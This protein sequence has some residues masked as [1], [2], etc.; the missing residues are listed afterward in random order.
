M[1]LSV[2]V[3]AIMTG[4]ALLVATST[5]IIEELNDRSKRDALSGL[6]NRRGFD[7]EAVDL[8]TLAD[9]FR[10]PV[11]VIIADID[12]FK[13]VNDTH[14]HA[15]GDIV[16]AELGAV[17]ASYAD[18]DRIAGRIG[19]EEFAL[20][21]P[22][23]SGE[24]AR[25]IAEAIRAEFA[26]IKIDTTGGAFSFTASFGAGERRCGEDAR[27]ALAKADEALYLAK[28]AGRNCVCG[29]ADVGVEQL[30]SARDK[31]ERRRNRSP[32]AE[33]AG[34]EAGAKRA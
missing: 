17:F 16:I 30:K 18:D 10:M 31:L 26:K 15:F 21:L 13:E 24:E 4:M 9:R 25:E 22:G 8:F 19:G 34:V 23:E 28:S 33:R 11:G 2:G 32:Q 14:G 3:C 7:E 20:L 5:E 1:H 6:L 29:E 12:R 27:I